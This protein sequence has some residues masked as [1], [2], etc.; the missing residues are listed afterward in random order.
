MTRSGE[1]DHVLAP[2]KNIKILVIDI[3]V[4][5]NTG[6]QASKSMPMGVIAQFAASGK[7]QAKKT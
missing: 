6:G 7:V 2:G 4:Y 3:E 5:S 1:L